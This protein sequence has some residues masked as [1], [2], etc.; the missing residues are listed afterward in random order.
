MLWAWTM[1]ETSVLRHILPTIVI[2]AALSTAALPAMAQQAAPEPNRP[3]AQTVQNDDFDWGWIGLLGLLG[4][5]G[6]IPRSRDRVV[7]TH[8]A[9]VNR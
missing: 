9:G 1:E 7:T 4:L 5:A 8:T 6:L 3:A 2:S